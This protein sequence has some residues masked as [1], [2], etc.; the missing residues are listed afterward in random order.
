MA[1]RYYAIARGISTGIFKDWND[2]YPKVNGY[3]NNLH[4]GFD[5]LREALQWLWINIGDKKLFLQAMRESPYKIP[6]ALIKEIINQ[7]DK[8]I[9]PD[10]SQLDKV[11]IK[12]FK[13]SSFPHFQVYNDEP[14]KELLQSNFRI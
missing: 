8:V 11:T 13:K 2:V 5:D 14:K 12:D 6:K 9:S 10:D 7:N 3:P 4:Q 1:Q